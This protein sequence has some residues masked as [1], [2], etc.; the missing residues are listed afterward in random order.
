MAEKLLCHLEDLSEGQALGLDPC[1]E[2]RDSIF[3][4]RVDGIVRGYR[5]RCPHL[6]VPME[7]RKDRFLSADRRQIVC[8]AHN[9]R[10]LPENG[11]CIYGPCLGQSLE[12]VPLRV[13]Q[14]LLL[15]VD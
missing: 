5:N 1:Q 6:G 9:A 3:V 13:E 15:L 2:G 14:G 7:Y 8:Y 10:F 4:I 12:P 11:L